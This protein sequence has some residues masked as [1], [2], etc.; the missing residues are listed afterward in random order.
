MVVTTTNF[1]FKARSGI[2][3]LLIFPQPKTYIHIIY[4]KRFSNY[5]LIFFEYF[6]IKDDELA[7]CHTHIYTSSLLRS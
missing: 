5:L 1:E 3:V 7:S 6:L 4:L 2:Y